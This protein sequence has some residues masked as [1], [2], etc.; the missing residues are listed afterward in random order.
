MTDWID[1]TFTLTEQTVQW[2]DDPPYRI[3]RV[4]NIKKSGD[5]NLSEIQTGV[6]AGTHMDAPLHFI[7]GGMDIAS[8]P[9]SVLC[10]PAVLVEV[11]EP[12]DVIAADLEQADIRP[13]DRVLLKTANQQLWNKS[14]FDD[15]F[16]AISA[17]AAHWLIQRQ[18][19]LVGIDYLSADGY[20]Q[21]QH[22][23]HFVL[24]GKG[25][26]LV[27]TL[28][29]AA[30]GAGRYELIALPLKLAASEGSPA[31]VIVRPIRE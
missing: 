18:V 8:V 27:E 10:G 9:L 12:R 30:V 11:H 24:M 25:V 29:L 5:C 3:R 19:P 6:H 16:Y 1:L 28:N 15:N 13:S 2:P 14:T 7:E 26:V 22:P 4:L 20:R 23:A 31:R 21:N 17:E